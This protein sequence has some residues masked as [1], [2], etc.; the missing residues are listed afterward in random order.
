M[1]PRAFPPLPC[2]R[3][4]SLWRKPRPKSE[5]IRWPATNSAVPPYPTLPA[6]ESPRASLGVEATPTIRTA[7]RV[8]SF[9]AKTSLSPSPDPAFPSRVPA[10]PTWLT[11]LSVLKHS[12]TRALAP[13]APLSHQLRPSFWTQLPSATQVVS[14]L[15][16]RSI[17]RSKALSLPPRARLDP[18]PFTKLNSASM[19]RAWPR[20]SAAPRIGTTIKA[21]P[22]PAP[23]RRA[24]KLH[25]SCLSTKAMA[26]LLLPGPLRFHPG[27]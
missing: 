21:I 8:I 22:L 15:R 26:E 7:F 25:L 18:T 5:R 20:F 11:A 16:S 14:P 23:A 12:P 9:S 1:P 13:S 24:G 19:V 4:F 6:A 27:A 3:S 2:S 17:G 10:R